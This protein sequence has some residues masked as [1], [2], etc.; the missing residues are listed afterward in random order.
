MEVPALETPRLSLR[1]YRIN[2]FESFAALNANEQARAHMGSLLN[3]AQSR[4]RFDT[5]IQE[6]HVPGHEAWAAVLRD[7][8][9]Y[10]GHCWL[11]VR[12]GANDLDFGLVLDP[13]VWRQGYGTE[14]AKAV[15]EHALKTHQRVMATVDLDHVASIKLLER[16]GMKRE[17]EA[18]DEKGAYLIY[19]LSR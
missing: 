3:R 7:S 11:T 14:I 9:A 18:Y 5:F 2:D 12:E 16:A 17:R 1:Q 8:G 19:A 4:Q 6:V 10:I 15:I 13:S